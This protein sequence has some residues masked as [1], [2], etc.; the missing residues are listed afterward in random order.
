M[1]SALEKQG[2][3]RGVNT[4]FESSITVFHILIHK[5]WKNKA[6]TFVRYCKTGI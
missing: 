2:T 5:M 6:Y 1:A 3:G 4:V